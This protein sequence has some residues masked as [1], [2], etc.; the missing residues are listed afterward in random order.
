MT[1]HLTKKKAAILFEKHPFLKEA[2]EHT[3]AF[4]NI[5]ENKDKVNAR[6]QFT[7][8]KNKVTEMNIDKFSTVLHSL[9]YHMEHILNFFDNRS[10][11]A[12]AVSFNSKIE[13]FKANLGGVTDVTFFLFKLEKLFA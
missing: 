12:N 8:W 9:E 3:L 13:G 1:G 7:E 11:N 6:V 10:T 4:R 2:Y 5:Y